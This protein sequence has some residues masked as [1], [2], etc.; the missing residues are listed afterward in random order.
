MIHFESLQECTPIYI[1]MEINVKYHRDNVDPLQD[2]ILYCR[3]VGSVA[4]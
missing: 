4:T 1:P 3:L 2:P